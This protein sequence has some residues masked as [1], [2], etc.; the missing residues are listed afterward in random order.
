MAN[1]LYAGLQWLPAA[2]AD[3]SAQ[4]RSLASAGPNGGAISTGSQIR[5]L[6]THALDENQLIR[7][8]KSIT[9]A[10]HDGRSLA[11]LTPLRLGLIGNGTLDHLALPL[12]A[13]AARHG[14]ALDCVLGHYDQVL[15]EAL[16][17][18]SEINS[19]KLDA[20]LIA[21]DYRGLP[22]AAT[23]G[24][25]TQAQ[26]SVDSALQYLDAVARGIRQYGNALPIVQ[27]LA[28]PPE[29]L[30]GSR[31]AAIAGTLR[32]LVERVNHELVRRAATS[33][34]LLFDVNVLAQTVGLA[35]WHSPSQWNLAKYPFADDFLP[36]YA[37]HV[38]R[39]L[40]AARGKSRRALVLDLDNTLWGGVIGDD[41]LDG[42]KVAQGDATGEAHL[43]VQKLALEL[44][45]RGVVLA[46]SSKNDDSTARLPFQKH[47]EMLLRENHFAVF[48]ANWNDKATN[49]QA[50]AKE[51]SLGLESLVFLDDN[52]VE[53]NLV[54]ELLP[55]VAVPELP[56]DPALYARTLNAAGYFESLAFLAEDR[57]R[58]AFY[59]DNARRVALQSQAGDLDAYLKSLDMQITFAP[60]D[61]V[62]RSRIVQLINK[63][64]QFNLTTRRYTEADVAQLEADSENFTLQVRLTDTFGDNGMIAVVICR[65]HREASSGNG[66]ASAGSWDIDTWLMSCRVLGRK[67]EDMV[68]SEV[69]AH[70]ARRG[71]TRLIGLYI[72]TERNALVKDHYAKLGFTPLGEQDGGITVWEM[73]TDVHSPVPHFV[74]HR[75]GFEAL[76]P[77]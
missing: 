53:R 2:P 5:R 26:V 43:C 60:F 42:I 33:E 55:E 1:D 46:V 30:F 13:S 35:N 74:V 15:Q 11:P 31:D 10:R 56:D 50:I 61:D 68:L 17:P 64:N 23:P 67:V 18:D 27:T 73:A 48:Q 25:D 70:A 52:P 71:V 39:L 75:T 32:N 16:A 36:L 51:L 9:A 21:V 24:D 14:V 6:A 4:C 34:D 69:R 76:L 59:Q 40:G 77:T 38:G 57:Q 19:A 22:M 29:T 54:R 12:I 63:S 62:G 47:P 28:P 8:G 37:E 7:L 45:E 44:R 41:L 58:A 65:P 3:F 66:H 20:V 49:I 72:P